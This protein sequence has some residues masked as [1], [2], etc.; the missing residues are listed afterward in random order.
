MESGGRCSISVCNE[1]EKSLDNVRDFFLLV[2]LFTAGQNSEKPHR[3]SEE[4][5]ILQVLTLSSRPVL[6]LFGKR[7]CFSAFFYLFPCMSGYSCL[8]KTGKLMFSESPLFEP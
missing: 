2:F 8:L 4:P 5:D 3:S 7:F 6:P 1:D